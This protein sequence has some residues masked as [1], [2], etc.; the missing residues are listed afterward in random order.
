MDE[1]VELNVGGTFLTTTWST[2]CQDPSIMLARMFS[3]DMTPSTMDKDDRFFID[4]ILALCWPTYVNSR[5]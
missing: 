2:L 3:G 5:S 4:R 1:I